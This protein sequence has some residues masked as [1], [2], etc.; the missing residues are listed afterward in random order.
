VAWFVIE[1]MLELNI[2]LKNVLFQMT[3]YIVTK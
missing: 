1:R 3:I 2:G